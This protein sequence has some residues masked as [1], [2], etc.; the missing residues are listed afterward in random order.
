METL[1]STAEMNEDL[2]PS[3]MKTNVTVSQTR[4]V[5]KVQGFSVSSQDN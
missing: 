3:L 5:H 4:E 2:R 1:E